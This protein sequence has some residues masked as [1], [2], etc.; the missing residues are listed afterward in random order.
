M[1]GKK[2]RKIFT[3]IL[4]FITLLVVYM[5]YNNSSNSFSI[6]NAIIKECNDSYQNCVV[7]IAE[8]TSFNWDKM[9]VFSDNTSNSQISKIIGFEYSNSDARYRRKIL[10]IMNNKVI[11]EDFYITDS[12]DNPKKGSAYYSYPSE[13]PPYYI[14]L[15]SNNALINVENKNDYFKLSL[16][17]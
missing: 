2:I 13:L 15:D 6:T 8:I 17:E 10:F 3:I 1:V 5:A 14:Y 9:Y 7:D 11:Y 12:F 4:L 16:N